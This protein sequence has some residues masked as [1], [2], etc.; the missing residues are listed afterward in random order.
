MADND[1]FDDERMQGFSN[2]AEKLLDEL[3]NRAKPRNKKEENKDEVFVDP[4]GK[5]WKK[6]VFSDEEP[7]ADK[8]VPATTDGRGRKIKDGKDTIIMQ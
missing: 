7:T 5:E 6:P 3:N 1:R 4:K 2:T 8:S